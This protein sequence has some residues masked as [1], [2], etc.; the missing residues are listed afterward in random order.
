MQA[1][2][3]ARSR[4]PVCKQWDVPAN[5]T[6]LTFAGRDNVTHHIE[7]GLHLRL[8]WLHTGGGPA[9]INVLWRPGTPSTWLSNNDAPFVPIPSSA[10]AP[11]IKPAEQWRQELQRELSKGWNT[12]MR[13]N[14]MRHLHLPSGFGVEVQLWDIPV[15]QPAPT[16]AHPGPVLQHTDWE[17]DLPGHDDPPWFKADNISSCVDRCISLPNCV[18]TSWNS[19]T[20]KVCNFKCST[21]TK[22]NN[23]QQSAVIV[24]PGKNTCGATHTDVPA[25]VDIRGLVDKCRGADADS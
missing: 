15:A 10:L 3:H 11:T 5:H 17:D 13:D 21:K 1:M 2:D 16:T 6:K 7:K 19:N 23:P 12:W 8:E 14:A 20:D 24:R 18:A 4:D 25:Q 9:H 22:R